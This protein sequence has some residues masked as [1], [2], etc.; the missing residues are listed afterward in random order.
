MLRQHVERAGILH[1]AVGLR[2]VDLDHVMTLRLQ[3][4]KAHQI[5]DILRRKQI[6]AGG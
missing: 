2:R 3:P 4:A 6:L 5:F 1:D